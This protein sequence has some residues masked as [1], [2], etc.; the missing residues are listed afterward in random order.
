MLLVRQVQRYHS[1][2]AQG[3]ETDVAPSNKLLTESSYTAVYRSLTD[4]RLS[5]ITTASTIANLCD[6]MVDGSYLTAS[7]SNYANL[8]PDGETDL[9]GQIEIIKVNTNRVR[10]A[11]SY[12]NAS[13]QPVYFATY[14][15]VGGF[16]GWHK[17]LDVANISTVMPISSAAASNTKVLGEKTAYDNLALKASP[18]FT[19]T[20]TV[21][22]PS[23]GGAATNRDYVLSQIASAEAGILY[24]LVIRTQG[25][26]ETMIASS[27]WLDAVSVALVG[28]FTLS[29]VNN[30]GVKIPSTVKQ[31]HGFNSAKITVTNFLYSVTTAKGGLWY[32][33]APTTDDCGVREIEVNCTG[34]AVSGRG[35]GFH[36]IVNLFKCKTA[37]LTDGEAVSSGFMNCEHLIQCVGTGSGNP[38][39]IG[40]Q[41]CK[42]LVDCKGT[43]IGLSGGEGYGYS[44]IE[45]ATACKDGGST[46]SMWGGTNTGIDPSAYKTAATVANETLN[47]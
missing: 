30:S 37:S 35:Y 29:T 45:R 18:T 42:H 17:Y 13:K 34:T 10:L 44:G 16:L 26:F 27:T 7:T 38:Y 19:G 1:L 23:V 21:P 15:N 28:Q 36:N 43:G 47:A 24:D 3:T 2:T 4:S 14:R 41:A 9:N 46:T 39:G 22:T 8:C 25:D 40:F 11:W 32:E 5:G 33:T 31:I 12:Q 20:V 6:A